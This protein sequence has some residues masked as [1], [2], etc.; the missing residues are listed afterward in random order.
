MT[1]AVGLIFSLPYY[2]LNDLYTQAKMECYDSVRF[3]F[4][5]FC[6]GLEA[7]LDTLEKLEVIEV[8]GIAH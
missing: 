5:L 3:S 7:F 8:V 4:L 6:L 2:M 1:S